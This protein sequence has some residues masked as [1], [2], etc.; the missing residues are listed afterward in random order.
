VTALTGILI[1]DAY[2]QAGRH[3]DAVELADRIADVVGD[4]PVAA[5]VHLHRAW[6]R[7]AAGDDRWVD[8][9][10]VVRR[11]RPDHPALWALPDPDRPDTA[12]TDATGTARAVTLELVRATFDVDAAEA[13]ARADGAVLDVLAKVLTADGEVSGLEADLLGRYVTAD[14]LADEAA[15]YAGDPV[16]LLSAAATLDRP[17]P[18]ATIGRFVDAIEQL[19]RTAA[20]A[21]GHVCTHE[22]DAVEA[23]SPS[24]RPSLPLDVGTASTCR[25]RV[26]D[27]TR[28]A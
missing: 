4:G 27:P 12:R 2:Q 13:A 9:A 26:C 3:D 1:A 28:W 14:E 18:E 8:D 22:R 15:S 23:S 25:H 20:L 11:L 7:R 6:L 5:E 17:I 21:D 19:A 16:R 10:A 24:S